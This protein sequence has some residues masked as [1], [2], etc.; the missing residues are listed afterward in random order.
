VLRTDQIQFY[1]QVWYLGVNLA[2]SR[3]LPSGGHEG[4]QLAEAG[5][6]FFINTLSIAIIIISVLVFVWPEKKVPPRKQSKKSFL[7]TRSNDHLKNWSFKKF[8]SGLNLSIK[9]SFFSLRHDF[10]SFSRAIA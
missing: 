1:S 10:N 4:Q 5:V 8:R 7:L 2:K 9:I 6:V 3:V